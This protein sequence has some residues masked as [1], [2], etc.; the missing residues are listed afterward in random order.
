MASIVFTKFAT[1]YP[2]WTPLNR[3]FRFFFSSAG[4]EQPNNSGPS[5]LNCLSL[6]VESI[7]P[8]TTAPVLTNMTSSDR[9]LWPV[10]C[11]TSSRQVVSGGDFLRALLKTSVESSMFSYTAFHGGIQY[12]SLHYHPSWN[13]VYV[14]TLR[15]KV[16][17]SI[18]RYTTLQCGN[19][20]SQTLVLI[21]AVSVVVISNLYWKQKCIG[22]CQWLLCIVHDVLALKYV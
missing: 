20:G 13:P 3:S 5:S 19:R 1:M 17:S 7:S 2:P 14:A 12:V 11:T 6:I 9:T 16:E 22:R 4:F 18:F 15:C 10:A 8:N 21:P